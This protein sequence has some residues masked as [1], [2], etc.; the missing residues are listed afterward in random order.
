MLGGMAVGLMP[1]SVIAGDHDHHGVMHDHAVMDHSAQEIVSGCHHANHGLYNARRDA[2][3]VQWRENSPAQ[4][5]VTGACDGE[6]HLHQLHDGVPCHER[7]LFRS[8]GET[9]HRQY[10]AV[11]MISISI[12]P[13]YDTPER[14]K[15]DPSYGLAVT[16]SVSRRPA[17]RLCRDHCQ[18][19]SRSG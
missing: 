1:L 11:R 6:L 7:H 10:A 2:D 13:E 4:D 17:E 9:G 14:L 3:V 18:R 12:D 8:S 19:N 16:E 5:P 15:T